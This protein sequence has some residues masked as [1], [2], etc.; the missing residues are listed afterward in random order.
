MQGIGALRMKNYNRRDFNKLALGASIALPFVGFPT[1]GPAKYLVVEDFQICGLV[2]ASPA[3]RYF[4][5]GDVIT[6]EDIDPGD[7]NRGFTKVCLENCF[8]ELV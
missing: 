1:L 2:G 4:V 6:A 3:D 5:V 8:I 7:E